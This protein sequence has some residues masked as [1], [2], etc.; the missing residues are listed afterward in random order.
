M[1]HEPSLKIGNKLSLKIG[2]HGGSERV[3]GR[4]LQ[5][6]SRLG[7]QR[8][9]GGFLGEE[10]RISASDAKVSALKCLPVQEIKAGMVWAIK[11]VYERQAV[12]VG[13]RC[14]DELWSGNGLLDFPSG[15]KVLMKE[16]LFRDLFTSKRSFQSIP[17]NDLAAAQP[18]LQRLSL[19]QALRLRLILLDSA[20]QHTSAGMGFAE[21]LDRV[22]FE[23][24]GEKLAGSTLQA[25]KVDC[26]KLGCEA[27]MMVAASCTI[28]RSHWWSWWPALSS[29]EQR[30]FFDAKTFSIS[31]AFPG[32]CV[33][34]FANYSKP[35]F[36]DASGG[37][38]WMD[39][40]I[41]TVFHESELSKEPPRRGKVGIA[42]LVS[43][44]VLKNGRERL[45]SSLEQC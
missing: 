13:L 31:T 25:N 24:L 32:T 12:C 8:K 45:R 43:P 42:G 41:K 3:G 11:G 5:A 22:L 16:G 28:S 9:S 18:D 44:D 4:V 30:V 15:R 33:L 6:I 23:R 40:Q 2:I 27:V 34:E 26:V 37:S 39:W 29:G 38:Q 20:S 17:K 35:D 36:N 21:S 14:L 7:K 10:G 19:V 1:Q